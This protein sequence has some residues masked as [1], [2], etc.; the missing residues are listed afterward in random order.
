MKFYLCELKINGCKNI[1]KLIDLKFYNS[2]IKS[3]INIENTN[4]KAIYGPNGAGKS[5]IVTAM[6]IYENLIRNENGLNDSFFSKFVKES[7]NKE[8]NKLEIEVTVLLFDSKDKSYLSTFR[9]YLSLKVRNN[10]V[11]IDSER[12]YKLSGNSILDNKFKKLIDVKEGKLL[13]IDGINNLDT[14]SIYINSLNLLNKKSII[15]IDI[16]SK[17]NKLSK[18]ELALIGLKLFSYNV[19]VSME[20]DDL[21]KNYLENLE[22][23]ENL[24]NKIGEEYKIEIIEEDLFYF[25]TKDRDYV[26]VDNYDSYLKNINKL[27]RFIKVFKPNLLGVEIDKKIND[28]KYYCNKIFKYQ[29]SEIDIEFESTGIKK[30]VR[31]FNALLACSNGKIV[32]ID[33]FDANLHDVYFAKLIEFLK[34]YSNGQL[35]FTTHNLEP[36]EVLKNNSHSLDFLSNDSRIASWIKN[37]NKSPLNKYVN[38]LI[39]YSPFNVHSIDFIDSLIEEDIFFGK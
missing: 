37:G 26:K 3:P 31:L 22:I 7:I 36:I 14:T 2:T 19:I 23:N 18:Y 4:I 32:F 38:G 35:C 34:N 13:E 9:H 28:G 33:E 25:S 16:E 15:S 29:N 10:N 27:Y 11:V 39:D 12:I 30:L 21:H 6:Y 1:N 17:K 5:A 20:Q 24:I 8:L